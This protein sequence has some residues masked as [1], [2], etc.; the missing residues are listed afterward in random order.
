MNIYLKL[1]VIL[2]VTALTGCAGDP[3]PSSSDS[4]LSS[5][6]SS[7][8]VYAF[9]PALSNKAADEIYVLTINMHT[10]QES[11]MGAKFQ[12]IADVIGKLGIDIVLMQECAQRNN[13]TVVSNINGVNIRSDNMAKILMEMLLTNYGVQYYYAWDWAHIGFSYYEE[14]VGILSRY[15]LSGINSRYLD[16][17]TSTSDLH[18]RKA[19][20]AQADFTGFGRVSMTSVHTSWHSTSEPYGANQ[21]SNAVWLVYEKYTNNLSNNITNVLN[22]LGGDINSQPTDSPPHGYNS[23]IMGGLMVDTLLS[24]YPTANTGG[25]NQTYRTVGGTYPGRIDYI[26]IM[27]NDQ[28]NVRYCEIV[29]SSTNIGLVSD[30]F[31]VITVLKKR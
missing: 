29:F 6:S 30:H 3:P 14:G 23:L 25:G 28:Y 11:G 16:S 9:S 27:S 7:S 8:S 17:R 4:S 22:I 21:I 12:K 10:Y 18:S 26:A 2:T 13:T 5:S 31:G 24:Y 20:N 1:L 15:P 19:V